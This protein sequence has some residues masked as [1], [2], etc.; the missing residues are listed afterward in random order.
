M[1]ML[2]VLWVD[3][4]CRPDPCHCAHSTAVLRNAMNDALR[5]NVFIRYSPETVA[6]ACIY[7]AARVKRVPLPSRPHWFHVFGMDEADLRDIA[8]AIMRLYG[9]SKPNADQL[10]RAVEELRARQQEQRLKNKLLSGTNTP[11]GTGNNFS[12]LAS[13][14]A[15]PAEQ[16]PGAAGS[17]GRDTPNGDAK[18]NKENIAAAAAAAVAKRTDSSRSRS[19]NEDD[20]RRKLKSKNRR[21]RSHHRS[22]SRS[23]VEKRRRHS[24]TPDRHRN[25][26]KKDKERSRDKHRRRSAERERARTRSR[27]PARSKSK[28]ERSERMPPLSGG[29]RERRAGSQER[30]KQAKK[31]GYENNHK[32]R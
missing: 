22:R 25:K 6:A 29:K 1:A 20:D 17:G 12:P 32:R 24:S 8:T 23:P 16:R 21:E 11:L 27:S 15:S 4:C 31:R 2:G 30:H 28:H 18:L 3:R 19:S 5:T 14:N 13:H 26:H 7:L 10:E 9:R